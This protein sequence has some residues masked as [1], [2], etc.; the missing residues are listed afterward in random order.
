MNIKHAIF[1]VFFT[2]FFSLGCTEKIDIDLN[3]SS[4]QTV[5]EANVST[6]ERNSYVKISESINFD[7]K[8]DFPPVRN[9]Q[10]K[11]SD[12]E[13]SEYELKEVSP[14]LYFVPN[15][16]AKIG[17]TYTLDV[18]ANNEN[19][20]AICK[21]SNMIRMD[22]ISV[23][24]I[25]NDNIFDNE[26][27]SIFDVRVHFKDP[28][29]DK[30]YYQFIEYINGYPIKSYLL[31][32]IFRDG[33]M[34]DRRLRDTDRELEEGDTLKIEM[35]CI[36]AEVFTYLK[37]LDESYNNNNS[38]PSNPVTNIEN[39]ALGYFSAHT[40]QTKSLIYGE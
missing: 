27:D 17:N 2:V 3:S 6:D 23:K 24:K 37:S 11:V 39:A 28:K 30:N 20:R 34:V 9:A 7:M 36:T 25:K 8:N 35:R 40:A 32:D 31:E 13:G 4:P 1:F 16:R 5:I 18:K 38:T 12:N 33:K 21:V 19:F 29:G 10:V 26:K 15:L 22:S 14:G